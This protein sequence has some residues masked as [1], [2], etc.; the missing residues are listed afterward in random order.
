VR[1]VFTQA[2]CL[3]ASRLCCAVDVTIRRTYCETL[4]N[5]GCTAHDLLFNNLSVL[6]L[7]CRTN[8]QAP[9]LE[10]NLSRNTSKYYVIYRLLCFVSFLY[11][12]CICYRVSL[13]FVLVRCRS[14]LFR[15]MSHFVY[16]VAETPWFSL[17]TDSALLGLCSVPTPKKKAVYT[18]TSELFI[19]CCSKQVKHFLPHFSS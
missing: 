4:C 17:L 18:L 15:G 3:F 5:D 10:A 19:F 14:L 8:G 7:W 9:H 13:L 6:W 2:L 11:F 16:A 1:L 12:P